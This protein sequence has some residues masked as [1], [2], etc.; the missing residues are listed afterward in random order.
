MYQSKS[1][2]SVLGIFGLTLTCEIAGSREVSEQSYIIK[3]KHEIFN[4]HSQYKYKY[5]TYCT[6]ED[7]SPTLPS[8]S[9]NQPAP[10]HTT[11]TAYH[12]NSAREVPHDE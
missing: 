12:T 7:S 1:A 2:L 9:N 11:Y 4:S 6:S 3:H 5:R 8:S 10:I